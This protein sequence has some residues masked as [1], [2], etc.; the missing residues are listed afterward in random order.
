[1]IIDFSHNKDKSTKKQI[2]E[3]SSV[4]NK[5]KQGK[6]NQLPHLQSSE[7][8]SPEKKQESELPNIPNTK[9]NSPRDKSPVKKTIEISTRNPSYPKIIEKYNMKMTEMRL[10]DWRKTMLAIVDIKNG[11]KP[12]ECM[13]DRLP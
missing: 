11:I 8:T 5:S 12:K 6:F 3:I 10:I 4:Q 1:M 9:Q 7:K 13:E 2:K